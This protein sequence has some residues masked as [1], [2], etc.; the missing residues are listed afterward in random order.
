MIQP[1]MAA[2]TDDDF[3]KHCPGPACPA[4]VPNRDTDAY[5]R[6]ENQYKQMDKKQLEQE[7]KFYE[8]AIKE[9]QREEKQRYE[10]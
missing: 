2:T 8:K 9:I 4:N 7:H 1:T 3:W 6:E 5:R 10:R